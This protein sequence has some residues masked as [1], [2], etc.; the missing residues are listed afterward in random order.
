MQLFIIYST[1][2]II[3]FLLGSMDYFDYERLRPGNVLQL[4]RQDLIDFVRIQ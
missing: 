3:W 4:S 2:D 1:L